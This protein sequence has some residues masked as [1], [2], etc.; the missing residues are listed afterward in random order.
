[1]VNFYSYKET[2]DHLSRIYKEKSGRDLS[3]EEARILTGFYYRLESM[4][5]KAKHEYKRRPAQ[6]SLFD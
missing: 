3:R 4:L 2:R 6:L 1:M 5:R